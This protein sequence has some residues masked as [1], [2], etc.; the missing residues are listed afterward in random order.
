MIRLA[1]VIHFSRTWLGGMNVI[2]NLINTIQNYKNIKSKL[3]IILLT[4]SKQKLKK[5]KIDK[6]VKIIE[7]QE[8]FKQ[9][10]FI[11]IIDKISLIFTG[12]TIF[13]EKILLKY[14]INYISHTT[15]I[16]GNKSFTKSIIW[17]PDF[18]YLHFP[19]FFSLKYKILK[20]INLQ[21]YKNH[22]Y[23]ILLSSN[24]AKKDLKKVCNISSN[25]ILVNRFI[26]NLPKYNELKNF[27]YLKKKYS[28]KKNFFYLPNQYWIHKNH[29]VVIQA[30]K[31]I[32][33]ESNK[34]IFIYSSG[35]KEDYRHPQ[36]FK[37][38]F[39]LVNKY[40]LHKNYI[41]LGLIPF[42]DVLSLIYH[43]LAVLNPSYFEGWSSTV[44]QAKA[45]NKR[46]ILS[47]IKVH[48]EQNPKYAYYFEP[49]DYIKLSRIL[50]K[51]NFS[52]KQKSTF[53]KKKEIS[54]DDKVNIYTKAYY[55]MI[56][57]K[58]S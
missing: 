26:F 4:N 53:N 6:N 43:S 46:I 36:N 23:K 58:L 42:I 7:N 3:E 25:K 50:L 54:N 14:K 41:Y 33:N 34:N 1:F 19:N 44:E 37:N 10:I 28:L 31:K 45:Y 22:A 30:L 9:N 57:K 47:K 48:K 55:Q 8:L 51:I 38:L 21:I 13:L 56:L 29:H 15:L 16:T 52:K 5:F 24:E 17:I 11:K 49:D 27:S 32:K 18:Q 39:E 35:S 20:K 2:L 12:K 40:K